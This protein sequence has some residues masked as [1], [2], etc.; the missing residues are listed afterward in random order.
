[1]STQTRK[2]LKV[3]GVH[4]PDG[5]K[6]HDVWVLWDVEEKTALA[7]WETGH[8]YRAKWSKSSGVDPRTKFS[9][10]DAAASL[11]PRQIHKTWPFPDEPPEQVKP[12]VL[13]AQEENTATP[14][15][16][17][18]DYDDVLEDGT[19]TKEVWGL[20]KRFGGPTFVSRSETGLHQ[21]VRG[22]LPDGLGKFVADLDDEGQIEIYDHA[23][24]T[25]ST[26]RHVR[27]S[28]TDELPEAQAAIDDTIDEYATDDHLQR[29]KR[30]RRSSTSETNADGNA[31]VSDTDG[32]R[33]P[34][35]SIEVKDVADAGSDFRRYSSNTR[36]AQVEGP[37]PSHGPENSSID[38]C[39]NF[40][41]ETNKNVWK[42]WL[43]DDGGG[44]LHLVAVMEGVVS[45]GNSGRIDRDPEKMLKTCLHARDTYC[46]GLK[47][48]KP[49]YSALVAVAR[50]V[51]I[52]MADEATDTLGE[53]AYK[54]AR[55]LYNDLSAGDV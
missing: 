26:W 46:S 32:T 28:P 52:T 5:L 21:W 24:M 43:H 4:V 16:V 14:K 7:P 13:L 3:D 12:T 10:A 25:G 20:L 54:L 37:H 23:R 41:V 11:P 30:Q 39:T 22:S 15:L 35:Y 44:G 51:G 8:M 55:R 19:V 38:E 1:M 53:D 45:C 17:F 40:G 31:G 49:P 34:Y 9:Q 47:D 18:I 29:I 6:H 48:E 2:R 27:E 36:G 42:C 50:K 33:S